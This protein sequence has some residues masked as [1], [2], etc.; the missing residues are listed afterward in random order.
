MFN[1]LNWTISE[2]LNID[3]F[4]Q[5]KESKIKFQ[6]QKM[7]QFKKRNEGLFATKRHEHEQGTCSCETEQFERK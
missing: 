5:S 7:V 4:N 2:L 6:D 3:N 1:L